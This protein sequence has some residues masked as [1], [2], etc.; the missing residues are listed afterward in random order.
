MTTPTKVL[1]SEVLN[2]GVFWLLRSHFIELQSYNEYFITT[3]AA[4]YAMNTRPLL[5]FIKQRGRESQEE[6]VREGRD[7]DNGRRKVKR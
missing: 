4:K 3:R 2:N 7:S 6:R 5:L 1:N